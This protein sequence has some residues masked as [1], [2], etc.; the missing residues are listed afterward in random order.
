MFNSLAAVLAEDNNECAV[1]EFLPWER[2]S[3][4]RLCHLCYVYGQEDA[5]GK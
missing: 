2:T 4:P 3:V 5:S 1:K